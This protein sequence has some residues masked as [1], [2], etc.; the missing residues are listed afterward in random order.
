MNSRK[1]QQ[2]KTTKVFIIIYFFLTIIGAFAFAI[3][4]IPGWAYFICISIGTII[5]SACIILIS[6]SIRE[7]EK[8]LISQK[9]RHL[10]K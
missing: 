6:K 3:N 2:L 7:A 10:D 1:N 9:H 4:S 5:Y 8:N